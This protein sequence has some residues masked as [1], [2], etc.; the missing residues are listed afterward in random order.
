MFVE[1]SSTGDP[2]EAFLTHRLLR[3]AWLQPGKL[4]SCCADPRGL[5]C[6]GAWWALPPGGGAAKLG[7]DRGAQEGA[8]GRVCI[9][10]MGTLVLLWE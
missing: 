2:K 6:R 8:L 1:V 5:W 9:G 3:E 10:L 4:Q 7:K